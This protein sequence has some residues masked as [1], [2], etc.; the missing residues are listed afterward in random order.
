MSAPKFTSNSGIYL[1]QNK[2]NGKVYIG[3]TRHLHKRWK[4]HKISLR[5]H[6]HRNR[7]LQF[8]WDKYGEESFQFRVLE[9]CAIEQLDE[10]EQHYLDIYMPKGLCYNLA[11]DVKASRKGMIVNE[12]SRA[13]MRNA[14]LGKKASPETRILMS[15]MRRGE[16][17]PLFGKRHSETTLEKM[18]KAHQGQSS[19]MKGR[20]HSQEANQKNSEAHR[21]KTLSTEHKNKISMALRGK[22]SRSHKLTSEQV[23]Q[24]KEI[25]SAGNITYI[26]IAKAFRVS[27]DTI[28][29]IIRGEIWK[30]D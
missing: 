11:K 25:Y 9:Y 12:E 4:E 2:T 30:D 6:Y 23:K 19:P 28:A 13:L 10:R 5:G 29:R 17:H 16:K 15:E 14:K 26:E 8:A 3:Q 7:Y 22:R 18:R 27:K 21:G 1:I 24:I 20:Q